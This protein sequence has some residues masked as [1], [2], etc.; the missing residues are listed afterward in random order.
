MWMR[1]CCCTI[2]VITLAAFADCG[3]ASAGE[4]SR[5]GRRRERREKQ[6]QKEEAKPV[7]DTAALMDMVGMFQLDAAEKIKE[8]NSKIVKVTYGLSDTIAPGHVME[9]A[10][11]Q[12]P[13]EEGQPS[14]VRLVIVQSRIAT[15]PVGA[16]QRIVHSPFDVELHDTIHRVPMIAIKHKGMHHPPVATGASDADLLEVRAKCIAERLSRAWNLLDQGWQLEVAD[17]R[18]YDMPDGLE[19]WRLRPPFEPDY[20]SNKYA[21]DPNKAPRI[22]PAIYVTNGDGGNPLRIMT[23]YDTDA[24]LTGHPLDG[25]GK[26][27]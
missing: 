2:A 22:F 3:L 18:S 4:S 7:I 26:D 8:Y 25:A 17:D 19:Q 13:A 14:E 23:I 20:A 12:E 15:V 16:V 1:M 5:E 10:I 9:A 6:R 11:E 24:H 27:S 21:T